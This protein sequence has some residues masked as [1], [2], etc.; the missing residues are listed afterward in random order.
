MD[1]QKMGIFI[2]QRRKELGLTQAELAEKLHVT[3]KAVSRW[4]RG[5]GLPDINILEPLAQV[6]EVNLI[7][8]AQ[9][10]TSRQDTISIREAEMIVSDT[11][12]LSKRRKLPQAVGTVILGLFGVACVFLLWLLVTEGSIVMYSVGSLVTGLA[13]W[14][15][16]IWQMTWSRAE[17]PAVFAVVSLG[18]ALASLAIQFFQLAQEVE[19]GDFAAIEDTIHPL[20]MVV[21]LFGIATLLLNLLM[22]LRSGRKNPSSNCA[23]LP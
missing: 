16:P 2:A 13:A 3:D 19:T 15:A 12:A 22:I 14:A 10:K 21:V 7:E 6:L 4:E 1:A 18:A 9:A 11:I 17:K 8:L 23:V 20:C 5:I